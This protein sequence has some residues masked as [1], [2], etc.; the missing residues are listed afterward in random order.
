MF[1]FIHL[2][3]INYMKKYLFSLIILGF[4]TAFV[5]LCG[6]EKQIP[7][8][9]TEPP[10]IDSTGN[11]NPAVHYKLNLRVLNAADISNGMARIPVIDST[12]D[13]ALTRYVGKDTVTTDTTYHAA[14]G[15]VDGGDTAF[16]TRSFWMDTI[17]VTRAQWAKVMKDTSDTLPGQWPRTGV[18]WFDAIRYCMQ[19]TTDELLTQ[20]YDTSAWN[21]Q[22]GI[23]PGLDTGA[24]GYRLPT[25]DEWEYAARAGARNL[26]YPTDNGDIS[27]LKAK[28]GLTPDTVAMQFHYIY[29]SGSVYFRIDR[30]SVYYERQT[31]S[32]IGRAHV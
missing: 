13:S 32:E 5:F 17:E 25:E 8:W 1:Y 31:G 18:N 7:P 27:M 28:Y 22:A 6:C 23:G 30:D 11:I 9:I 10:V 4:V 2:K 20:C 19:K 26:A 16:I 21:P 24:S 12:Y 29:H 15:F 3:Q 14:S